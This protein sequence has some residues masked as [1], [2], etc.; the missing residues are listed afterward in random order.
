[1]MKITNEVLK[2][3]CK[4]LEDE[5]KAEATC[6]KYMR[7]IR[8]FCE[9]MK[10]KKLEKATVVAYKNA[11]AENYAPASVNSMLS[12]LNTFF[13]FNGW[14]ELHLKAL[15]IQRRIFADKEKEL[16]KAEYERLLI[17]A[18]NKKNRRLYLLMQTICST[19]IRVSEL[20]YITVDAVKRERV[21]IRNKGKIREI[22]LPHKLCT[23]LNIYIKEEKREKGSV[24][25]TKKGNPLNRTNIWT[26]MKKL[27]E[28]AGVARGKVFPHNLRHLFART[29]YNLQKDIVRLADVLGHTNINT[30]RIYT[31]ENGDAYRM[32]L[33]QLDLLRT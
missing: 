5:E 24:F 14:Y 2:N 13:K 21:F 33:Q 15:K 9:W 3:F 27:C 29:F 11:L 6:E 26:D 12:S 16:T 7:D 25:V 1:M 23:V 17:A 30:T 4:Y 19:G 31:M 8:A 32:Q 22:I 20:K 18:Q 10:G 28:A